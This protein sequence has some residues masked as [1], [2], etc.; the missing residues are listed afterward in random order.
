MSTTAAYLVTATWFDDAQVHLQVDLDV[1][2]PALATE[3]NTFWSGAEGRLND[4]NGDVVRAVVRLFGVCAIQYFM[5]NGGVGAQASEEVSRYW[6]GAVI[7]AQGEG[8]PGLDQLGIL[9]TS[10]H[11]GVVEFEDV[12]LE[13]V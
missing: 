4:E 2:T 3:I 11:V 10:A 5:E 8:W 6:T 13:A 7:K 12:Q 1:L 9:I